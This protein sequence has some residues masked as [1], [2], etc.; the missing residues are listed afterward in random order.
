MRSSEKKVSELEGKIKDMKKASETGFDIWDNEKLKLEATLASVT[1]ELEKE[2]SHN[3]HL[4]A[5]KKTL[6][7]KLFKASTFEVKLESAEKKIVEMQCSLKDMDATKAELRASYEHHEAAKKDSTKL[8]EQIAELEGTIKNISGTESKLRDE[9]SRLEGELDESRASESVAKSTTHTA[10]AE[11]EASL[12]AVRSE[13]EAEKKDS[14]D[15]KRKAKAYV[16]K[17]LQ[18]KN[19]LSGLLTADQDKIRRKDIELSRLREA[20]EAATHK[21]DVSEAELARLRAEKSEK[22]SASIVSKQAVEEE[23]INL[24]RSLDKSTNQ[25]K[26]ESRARKA[27]KME[28]VSLAQQLDEQAV[29]LNRLS[30]MIVST[31]DQAGALQNSLVDLTSRVIGANS[32][33]AA[34]RNETRV[35]VPAVS[36]PD[37]PGPQTD[38]LDDDFELRRVRGGGH[39]SSRKKCHPAERLSAEVMSLRERLRAVER[40]ER[41]LR[42]EATELCNTVIK[43]IPWD[44]GSICAVLQKAFSMCHV[45]EPPQA[46]RVKIQRR[47]YQKVT[48]GDLGTP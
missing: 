34:K 2:K 27:A 23:N 4:E 7:E 9:V 44:G 19:K 39:L 26:E 12:L 43:D 21:V 36:G 1:E 31:S 17:L 24:Q 3:N 33:V 20:I 47:R 35:R 32:A 16:E 37:T 45:P 5:T 10:V 6:E 30:D 18:E 41:K 14:T 40:Q 48:E 13:L 38:D 22:E 28:T 46:G 29:G 8:R 15:K 11:V 25:L 42:D